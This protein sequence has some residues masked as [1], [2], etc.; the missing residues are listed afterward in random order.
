VALTRGPLVYCLESV[1][2]P[3]LDLFSACL[4][5]DSF[6]VTRPR[7][8]RKALEVWKSPGFGDVWLLLGQTRDGQP[9]TAIP[10]AY[11]ANRGESQMAVVVRPAR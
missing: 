6:Q 4:D 10:Y 5:L 11:W 2:N 8:L 3:E 1:D 9:V 7:G